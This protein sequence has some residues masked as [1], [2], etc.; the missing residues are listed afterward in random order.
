MEIVVAG[1]AREEKN[2]KDGG[3]DSALDGMVTF[4]R[5]LKVFK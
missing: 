3:H 2:V 1:H 5:Y 4:F